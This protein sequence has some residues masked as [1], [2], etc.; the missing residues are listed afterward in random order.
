MRVLG[1]D[2]GTQ[3]TGWAIVEYTDH[4]C[5]ID[6]GC[7]LRTSARLQWYERTWQMVVE[8]LDIARRPGLTDMAIELPFVLPRNMASSVTLLCGTGMYITALMSIQH[9]DPRTGIHILRP[10]EVKRLV[11]GAGN[12]RKERV[13]GFLAGAWD[14]PLAA[15]ASDHESDAV[16]VALSVIIQ[17]QGLEVP[18]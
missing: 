17:S 3:H 18:G 2:P 14:L 9:A 7:L 12:S 6:S 4:L 10:S 8:L 13:A 5:L 16:A 1:V 15:D 11:T